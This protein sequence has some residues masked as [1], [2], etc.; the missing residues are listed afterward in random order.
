MMMFM[1][2][3]S[4]Y[5]NINLITRIVIYSDGAGIY[6]SDDLSMICI[7]KNTFERLK[8]YLEMVG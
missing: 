4:N 5:I 3:K 6:M 2:D 1:I 8:K 7:D